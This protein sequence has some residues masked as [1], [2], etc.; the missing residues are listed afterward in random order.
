MK[1]PK[2][3]RY[4]SI[5]VREVDEKC[6]RCDDPGMSMSLDTNNELYNLN[7]TWQWVCIRCSKK[8]NN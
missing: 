4:I 1:W 5:R 8:D 3:P 2:R 6:P 7:R